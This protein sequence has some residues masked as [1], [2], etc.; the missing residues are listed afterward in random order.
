[1]MAAGLQGPCR[2]GDGTDGGMAG[3]NRVGAQ[4]ALRASALCPLAGTNLQWIHCSWSPS[5]FWRGWV[6]H[7][8]GPR[9][10]RSGPLSQRGLL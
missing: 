1:M 4:P 7:S 9:S 8:P 3:L 10:P 6:S 2:R 5:T